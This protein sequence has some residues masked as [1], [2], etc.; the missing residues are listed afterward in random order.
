MADHHWTDSTYQEAEAKK[1]H[2]EMQAQHEKEIHLSAVETKTYGG[3]GK[4]P[5]ESAATVPHRMEYLNAD[6]VFAVLKA[7]KMYPG[8]KIAVLNFASYQTPGGKYMEGKTAQEESLCH[9]ST[10]YECLV[11]H[12]EFYEWNKQHKNHALYLDRALYT[13]DVLFWWGCEK[14]MADVITCSAP[15]RTAYMRYTK[16][17][18]SE[19][20][21]TNREILASRIR[22]IKAIAEENKVDVLIL[23]AFGCGSYGQDQDETA[24]LFAKIFA[25]TSIPHLVFAVPAGMNMKN[26]E[27][28]RK[29]CKK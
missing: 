6:T 4:T 14:T 21:Q 17:D 18:I 13:P 3:D 5:A 15:N 12:P 10:L 28:F 19:A 20:D 26:A 16:E 25:C 11:R 8:A 9:A 2:R 1:H 23:G 22:F 7:A 27:A 29:V 24:E